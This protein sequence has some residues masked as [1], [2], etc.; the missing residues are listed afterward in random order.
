MFVAV[1]VKAVHL[2]VVSDLT[3]AAFIACL[4]R[5]VARRG[6]PHTIWSDHGSNFVGA[7]RELAELAAFLEEQRALSDIPDFCASQ[8]IHWSFIPE[9]APHF[10]GLWESAVKGM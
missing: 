10:G 4:R 8:N 3:S 2:D 1:S 6:K 7:S 5:F 9:H